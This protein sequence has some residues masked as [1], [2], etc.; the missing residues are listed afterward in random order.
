[1]V[2]LRRVSVHGLVE[3]YCCVCD[4][5]VAL[6]LEQDNV[7]QNVFLSY[8]VNMTKYLNFSK[9]YKTFEQLGKMLV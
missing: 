1:M 3:G 8:C 5:F 2:C 7:V 9:E 6:L 4:K